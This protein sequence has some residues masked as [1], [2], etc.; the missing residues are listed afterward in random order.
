MTSE[1][2]PTLD[3]AS[4][5]ELATALVAHVARGC[6]VRALAIKGATLQRYGL[7]DERISSDV[8]IL[9]EPGGL[10]AVLAELAERG[11][12]DRPLPFINSQTDRHSVTLSH[13]GWPCDLDVHYRFPGFAFPPER[14]FD[15]L[16][17]HR[18]AMDFAGRSVDVP[19][20]LSSIL[21]LGLHSLRDRRSRPRHQRELEGLADVP[22]SDDDRHDLAE[23][24]ERTG[25]VRAL[26]DLLAR[27]GVPASP[28]ADE[29]SSPLAPG[30]SARVVADASGAWVW[31][32]TI[33]HAR[34]R[35]KPRLIGRA[36]W[37][38]D[39]DLLLAQPSVPDRPMAKLAA[40]LR[41]LARGFA[42]IPR[43][44]RAWRRLRQ[45]Q[46][47]LKASSSAD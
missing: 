38:T 15:E 25:C 37:P 43:A 40:R 39:R 2:A 17:A 41:R 33:F 7:R 32:G 13:D 14:V 36:L 44:L 6:G 1:S 11:W 19:D 35:D 4:A 9:V 8:D 26:S 23:R 18:S 46:G 31:A 22:L 12:R 16:W 24:A 3:L 45:E 10:E 47:S 27:L 28:S 29:W 30:W 20:R 5:G 21:I 34:W 42:G